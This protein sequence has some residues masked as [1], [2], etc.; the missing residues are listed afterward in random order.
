MTGEGG[1]MSSSEL[2]VQVF[3]RLAEG[4]RTFENARIMACDG[5]N[6]AIF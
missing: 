6:V 3:R 1:T 5:L 4:T 2:W